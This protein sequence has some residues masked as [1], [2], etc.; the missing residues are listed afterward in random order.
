[1]LSENL[2]IAT[3]PV[4]AVL[5]K[6]IPLLDIVCNSFTQFA[7]KVTAHRARKILKGD[8]YQFD[9][10]KGFDKATG[11]MEYRT[12]NAPNEIQKLLQDKFVKEYLNP[13]LREINKKS[14]VSHGFAEGRSI[15]TMAQHATGIAR[16]NRNV[17]LI[18]QDLEKAFPTVKAYLIKKLFRKLFPNFTGWQLHAI[19][20]IC[21]IKGELPMGSPASPAI[22]NLLL[23]NFDIEINDLA[24][25]M[26]GRAYRY[27]D[28]I[29]IIAATQ[30]KRLIARIRAELNTI[31]RRYKFR[32][33]KRKSF[34]IRIGIDSPRAE[35]TGLKIG[36]G[37]FRTSK[38]HRHEL[39][40]RKYTSENF[41]VNLTEMMGLREFVRYCSN[42]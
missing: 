11:K 23:E 18:G 1:M 30:D 34:A 37:K 5:L 10:P 33:H 24:K 6:S 26:G 8:Y 29:T 42:C 22:L 19:T 3:Q 41:G 27:A 4:E 9:I 12:I 31:I 13:I 2:N 25:K 35:L 17:S 15:K 14:Q 40:R 28:D 39:R 20:K 16:P 21:T 36:F 7:S 32:P 38:R